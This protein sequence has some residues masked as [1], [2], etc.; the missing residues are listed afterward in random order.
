ML[1][2]Y[3]P[4]D[5]RPVVEPF[6]GSG[7]FL[8][9]CP[10]GGVGVDRDPVVVALHDFLLRDDHESWLR[11]IVYSYLPNGRTEHGYYTLRDLFN[12]DDQPL[13]ERLDDP[14][15][16]A[17]L[18]VLLQLSFNSLLRFNPKGGKY[19]VGY[20]RKELDLERLLTAASVARS[21]GLDFV[22]GRYDEV[23]VKWEPGLEPMFY[24]DPPY[25]ASKYHYGTWTSEDEE[26]LHA[27]IDG[28]AKRGAKFS[29]TSTLRHR[30]V[31]NGQLRSWMSS[32]HVVHAGGKMRGWSS[33]VAS[34]ARA[35]DTDE[36]VV[37]NFVPYGEDA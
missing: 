24:L 1:W 30:G 25:L 11:A 8:Y 35:E 26:R 22:C 19:N 6:L 14:M 20:G 9:N 18:H 29:L 15:Y 4:T 36:V 32:Y 13:V 31:E 27:W 23:D 10:N 33:A 5:G 37:S 12:R 16:A 7:A 28:L 34:V 17:A 3:V 2:R 21:R